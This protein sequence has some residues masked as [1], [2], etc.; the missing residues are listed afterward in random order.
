M[1]SVYMD[2]NCE[3][4]QHGFLVDRQRRSYQSSTFFDLYGADVLWPELL[5][6]QTFHGDQCVIISRI[7]LHC[8]DLAVL[9]AGDGQNGACSHEMKALGGT[10][11]FGD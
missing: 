7:L 4:N 9:N 1:S 5:V 3:Y 8:F 10:E 6:V 11:I 2:Q